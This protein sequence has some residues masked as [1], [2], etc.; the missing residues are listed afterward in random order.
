M[1]MSEL[2]DESD[3]SYPDEE[4]EGPNIGVGYEYNLM[5]I[6]MR[7]P[8]PEI[9]RRSECCRTTSWTWLGHS[10]EWRSI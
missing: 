5:P 2:S 7:S 3:L 6:L 10:S 8:S 4:D 1:S 9:H